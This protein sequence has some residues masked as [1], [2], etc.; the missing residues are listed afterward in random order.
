MPPFFASKGIAS[1]LHLL[2]L[3]SIDK[4]HLHPHFQ[5]EKGVLAERIRRIEKE[6]AK[7]TTLKLVGRN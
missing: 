1:T 4:P 5:M 7:G 3:K 2:C 6:V